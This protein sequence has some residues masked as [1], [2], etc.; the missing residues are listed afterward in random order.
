MVR[1]G[2][3]RE[4]GLQRLDLLKDAVAEW[5]SRYDYILFDLPPLLLSADA[6]MLVDALGQVFL[7]LEAEAV[8][9]G[10]ISRAK[11]LLQKIDPEAVGVFVSKVPVFRGSGYMEGLIAETLTRTRLRALHEHVP[12]AARVGGAAREMG[13]GAPSAGQVSP[14]PRRPACD[15][16]ATYRRR[17]SG[18]IAA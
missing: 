6:E 9:A 2:G 11:R 18:L 16:S 8:S 1:I 7:V 13:G 3:E 4:G 12:V 15:T 5:S 10:E 14:G 17:G